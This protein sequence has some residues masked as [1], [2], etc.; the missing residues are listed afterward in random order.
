MYYIYMELTTQIE[1]DTSTLT[2]MEREDLIPEKIRLRYS[3]L[4]EEL[5]YLTEQ[6][7]RN[8]HTYTVTDERLRVAFWREIQKSMKTGK[9]LIAK[10]VFSGICSEPYF[11]NKFLRNDRKLAWMLQPITPYESATSALLNMAVGRYEEIINMDITTIKKT[12]VRVDDDGKPVFEYLPQ[13]DPAKANLLINVITKLEDR[14]KGMAIQ[15]SIS[16][17]ENAPSDKVVDMNMEALDKKLE[18]LRKLSGT[19]KAETIVD[20]TCEVIDEEV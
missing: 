19:K 17:K 13:I 5:K 8:N 14:V 2:L 6:E 12:A 4:P 16:V 18:E 15:K 10:R 11:Y 20:V 9:H 7:L 3:E 1:E